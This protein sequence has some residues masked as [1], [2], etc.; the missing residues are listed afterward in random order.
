MYTQI[1]KKAS[2][3]LQD[4]TARHHALNAHN[5]SDG[6][7]LSALSDYA[8]TAK[9]EELL[10]FI[11]KR[12][13]DHKS[14]RRILKNILGLSCASAAAKINNN[15]AYSDLF[16]KVELLCSNALSTVPQEYK[17]DAVAIINQLLPNF[18]HIEELVALCD[19]LSSCKNS[20]GDIDGKKRALL[21]K[22]RS[23]DDLMSDPES[24]L[25]FPIYS[26]KRREKLP[27]GDL[28]TYPTAYMLFVYVKLRELF[29]D[30]GDYPT[31][32][33]EK[34]SAL[35]VT[36][37]KRINHDGYISFSNNS[38]RN[39]SLSSNLFVYGVFSA[40]DRLS[41]N[42]VADAEEMYQTII[43]DLQL[44]NGLLSLPY[45]VS[46][47][48]FGAFLPAV[49]N[50]HLRRTNDTHTALGAFALSSAAYFKRYGDRLD[51]EFDE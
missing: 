30:D 32:I 12:L 44:K 20:L 46:I 11:E 36:L 9:N 19:L 10:R 8:L 24:G 16:A 38:E 13:S 21:T 31:F 23:F 33:D 2:N 47:S 5:F 18:L 4:A 22:V 37:H 1:L 26:T 17:R 43:E 42:T 29:R 6:F 50:S 51:K 25:Y 27:K 45:T 48:G 41:E 40:A 35:A 15:G 7:Y 28:P 49:L 14:S 3:L 39:D 34:I